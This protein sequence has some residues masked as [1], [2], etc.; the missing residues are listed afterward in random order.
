MLMRRAMVLVIAVVVVATACSF[1][2]FDFNGDAKADY[3][4]RDQSTGVWYEGSIPDAPVRYVGAA[5]DI[6]S[7]LV[8]TTATGS[9][10]TGP[11][12]RPRSPLPA[13]ARARA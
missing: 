3:V 11:S 2:P 1:K 4:W 10:P 13:R 9:R 5:S 8:L 6:Q 7:Q 12:S